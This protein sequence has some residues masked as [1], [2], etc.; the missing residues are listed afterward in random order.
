MDEKKIPPV[1]R[2]D[3]QLKYTGTILKIYEDTVIANGHEAHW[4]Y[5]HH[6]GAAAVVAVADDGRLLMVRQ[7]R[8]ALDR[9]TLEIPAGKLDEPGEP[10]IDC[11]YREL[12]EETGYRCE[13]LEYLMS[14]N[15]TVAFCDEFIDIYV[16]RDLIPSHQHLDEDEV[17]NVEPWKLEDLMELIFSGKMTD[18]KTTAAIL[19]YARKYGK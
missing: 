8:N 14:M 15:T 13:H 3:R 2:K 4:D 1:I 9:E 7:Y 18:A 12:E 5:I 11:A 17:I 10:T 6:D 19:A 16:A